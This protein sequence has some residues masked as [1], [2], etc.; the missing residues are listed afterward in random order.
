M[1]IRQKSVMELLHDLGPCDIFSESQTHELF[2]GS[3]DTDKNHRHRLA[4]WIAKSLAPD[5]EQCLV[6]I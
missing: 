5:S 6:T 2:D 1:L 3:T 4:E